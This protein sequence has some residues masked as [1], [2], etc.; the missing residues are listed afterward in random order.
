M[1]LLI[2]NFKVKH[3]LDVI[4]FKNDSDPKNKNKT[5]S[6]QDFLSVFCIFSLLGLYDY[7]HR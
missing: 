4:I 6:G 3:V 2:L 7:T 1:I 5:P